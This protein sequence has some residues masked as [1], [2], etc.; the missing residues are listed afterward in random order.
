MPIV[1]ALF[2]VIHIL[3][4]I[5]WVGFGL[6]NYFITT[7]IDASM[8]TLGINYQL[9][10]AKHT[11][12]GQIMAVAVVATT[13]AGLALWGVASPHKTLTT[14]AL[15]ILG[16]GSLAGLAAF[17]HGI[18]IG[19]KSDALAK[20]VLS[21]ESN[22]QVAADKQSEIGAMIA[23]LSRSAN[24]GLGMMAVALLCMSIY[25]QF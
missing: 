21:A 14:T 20:A 22:G 12:F 11:K 17:G 5:V 25:S 4:A 24:V 3:G 18:S 16:I 15:A 23:K 13:L 1:I 10:I 9:G 8:P 6:Y 2:R 7:R 19:N